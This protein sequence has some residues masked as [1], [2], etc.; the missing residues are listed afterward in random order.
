MPK[1]RRTRPA[2]RPAR[3]RPERDQDPRLVATRILKMGDDPAPPGTWAVV[4]S[5]VRMD[6]GRMLNWHPPQPVAF[7]LIEGK[8]LCDRA[9]PKRRR[10]TGNLATRPNESYGPANSRIPLDILAD[11]TAA[12]LFAFTAIESLANHSIDQLD[13]SAT[14]TVE[15]GDGPVE[16]PRDDMVRRLGISEKLTLAVP[17]L[18]DGEDFKGT[19]PWER[20]RHLKRLR[21]DLV[22]VKQRGDDPDPDVRT[23]YDRLILGDG[24]EC[25]QDALSVVRAARPEFLP[26]HVLQ[27]LD[28]NP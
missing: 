13:E 15:R 26:D 16:I 20:Y 28:Y 5:P 8:R 11:L 1:H 10:L 18:A 9:V 21:D 27:A 24:D 6:D 4:V 12:V 23:A 7:H 19:R 2:H 17:L 22:H 25:W 3:E 14:V